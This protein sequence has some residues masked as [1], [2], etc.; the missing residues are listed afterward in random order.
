MAEPDADVIVV[1]SGPAGAATAIHLARRGR[2]VLLLEGRDFAHPRPADMRSGEVLS[3]GGQREL[4]ALGLSSAAAEWRLD[5]FNVLHNHW[6]NGRSTYDRLPRGLAF[7][8]TDRG[9]LDRALFALARTEGVDT[10]DGCRV[11]DLL[12][13]PNGAVRG[14]I[15]KASATLAGREWRAPIVVDASGR[16]SAILARLRLKAPEREFRRVALVLFFAEMADCAPGVWEQYF[17]GAHNTT[18]RGARMRPAL[19][20][21]SFETDLDYRAA[22]AARHGKMTPRDT[23]LAMLAELHPALHERFAAA[24]A[25]SH[26]AA[27]VPV[28]FR[29]TDITHDGLIMVGDATGYLDPSTGQGIEF[30]LRT[31]RLA[32]GAID[33]ALQA[34]DYRRQRFAPYLDGRRREIDGA[35]RALRLYLRLSRSQPILRLASHVAPVRAAFTRAIVTP[36]GGGASRSF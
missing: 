27:Y 2:R 33:A 15:T 35:V 24:P 34:G 3:P 28:G 9:C 17:F 30:A 23:V 26:N 16:R 8:Q 14:V 18:L 36:K 7:W 31:A 5:S 19:Y 4:A 12:R 11:S 32:A 10:R 25:L 13:G 21:Y 1:G 6:P 20:R 22:F 29:V